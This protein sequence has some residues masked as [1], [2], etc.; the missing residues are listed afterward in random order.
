MIQKTNIR[1]KYFYLTVA[2]VGLLVWIFIGPFIAALTAFALW[3]AS[4]GFDEEVDVDK[5]RTDRVRLVVNEAFNRSKGVM[6]SNVLLG[7]WGLDASQSVGDDLVHKRLLYNM[8]T[9]MNRLGYGFVPDFRYGHRRLAFNEPCVVYRTSVNPNAGIPES[10]HT[11]EL[12]LKLLAITMNGQYPSQ[13][14][15]EFIKKSIA[16]L[17]PAAKHHP[18]LMAF[19]LWQVQKKQPYDKKTKDEVL[20]LPQETKRVFL[21]MLVESVSTSGSIDDSRIEALKKILPTLDMNPDMIHSL[22]H[23]SLTDEAFALFEDGFAVIEPAQVGTEYSIPQQNAGP[24]GC[25]QELPFDHS[26]QESCLPDQE[27]QNDPAPFLDER[28]LAELK[29]HTQEAQELLADIFADETEPQEVG[30]QP[31]KTTPEHGGSEAGKSDSDPMMQILRRLLEKDTWRR[32][33]V[34]EILGAGVMMGSALEKINDYS[35]SVV[36]DAVIED[37]DEYIYVATEYAEQLT[38]DEQ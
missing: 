20:V 24:Q 22:L 36:D 32:D 14:D 2:A 3:I 27:A 26:Q 15:F 28:R 29:A 16:T 17:E 9:G 25:L 4:F 38:P 13:A 18:H 6:N 11:A 5:E 23:Q 30:G 21:N 7:A 35:Y 1:N 33:E 19:I 34:Q 31:G 8:M 37:A 12:F 10:V